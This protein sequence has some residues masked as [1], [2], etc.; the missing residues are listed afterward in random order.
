MVNIFCHRSK[1]GILFKHPRKP[2]K[3]GCRKDLKAGGSV[4]KGHK[5]GGRAQS[6]KLVMFS[7]KDGQRRNVA[8]TMKVGGGIYELFGNALFF[9]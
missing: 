8:R 7:G 3:Q 4:I 5:T 9:L 1:R 2:F 6:R